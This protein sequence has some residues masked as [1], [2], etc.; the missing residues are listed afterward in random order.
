MIWKIAKKDFLLNLMTFKFAVGTVLCV[1][2]MA[3]FMPVLVSDYQQRLKDYNENVGANEAELRKVKVYKNITPTVYRPPNLL[4]VFAEGIDKHVDSSSTVTLDSV[5]ENKLIT[6]EDSNPFLSIFPVLDVSLIFEIVISVLAILMAYSVVSGEREWGTLKLM[7]SDK[8]PRHQVLLGKLLA[9]LM[10]LIV[11]VTALFLVGLLILLFSPMVDL[12]GTDWLRVGLIYL[13]SMVFVFVMFNLGLVIS[14]LARSSTTALILGLFLWVIFVLVIPNASAYLASHLSPIE[15]A[16]EYNAK[17]EVVADQCDDEI[18]ELTEDIKGG[19]MQSNAPGAF[20]QIYV[21]ICDKAFTEVHQKEYS[22]TEPIKT[23]YLDKIS[24]VRQAHFKSLIRQKRLSDNI[25]SG[26]PITLYK[27]SMS[28]LAGTDIGNFEHFTNKVRVYRNQVMD[29]ISVKTNNFSSPSYF[30]TCKEGDHKKLMELYQ[31][32]LAAESEAE[33][34]ERLEVVR[35][36]YNQMMEQTPSLGL[37]DFPRFAYEPPSIAETFQKTIP[38]LGLLLFFNV[39]LFSISFV[40]FLKYD[41][42]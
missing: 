1:V 17:I 19:G 3:V 11:P 42:R 14:C 34:A 16:K 30:T 27:N 38:D 32:Y 37:H 35:N 9:G 21:M 41:V 24:Q 39:L 4:S 8:A 7:L 18:D 13:T 15:S 20:N 5:S 2:L 33:K 25:A 22:V 40:A 28:V 10:T 31:P 36:W 6:T 29:Y 26:S 12:A 23:K